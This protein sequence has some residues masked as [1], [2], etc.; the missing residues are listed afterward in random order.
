MT[1][2]RSAKLFQIERQLHWS[3]TRAMSTP[4]FPSK[5][6]VDGKWVSASSGKTFP[7]HNPANGQVLTNVPSMVNSDVEKAISA[8]SSAFKTW[9]TTPAKDRSILLRKWY[10]LINKKVDLFANIIHL[11]AGKSI[12]EAKTEVVYGN[13]FLEW[14]S[15][16]ARRAYG[17]VLC[18]PTNTKRLMHIR[19]P[20][21]V[22]AVITPWNFPLAMITRKAGAA[23]AAGCTCVVKPAEDTP[24]TALA[25]AECAAEAGI[26]RGVINVVTAERSNAGPVGQLLC[27]SPLV[28]VVTFT[29]STNVGKILYRHCAEGIKKISLELGGNA[30]FIVFNSADIGAATRGAI[31]SKFRNC[32]QT[33]VSANRFLLQDS[34]HDEFVEK[35]NEAM[36]ACLHLGPQPKSSSTMMQELG[37]LI[38]E[39]QLK[40]VDHMV[41]DAIEKGAKVVRGAKRATHLGDLYYEPTVLADVTPDMLC[42][43]EE[44]F[45]PV[46]SCIRFKTE[47]EVLRIANSSE[48]GLAGYFFSQDLS[49][50]FRV[51]EAL[52]VGMV[53]INEGAISTPEAAFGGVKQSGLGREGSYHG[54]E[55]FME[56][57]YMCF[58]NL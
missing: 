51:A 7:V 55:E 18:S 42:Y 36:D 24:I 25:L 5:C 49:Q 34:I 28:S 4:T 27:Q 22:A 57:K 38:N 13:S 40:K 11:E 58:G 45:G 12:A 1:L 46:V 56:W 35:L 21:G 19:Q 41:Q 39:A 2:V 8:A 43:N 54:L 37:P 32:G 50:I 3:Y 6:F 23:L 26:P 52:E 20:A 53:G 31:A 10:D 14:F 17:D 15:E 29:G 44:I 47:E 33:C 30:P 9:K 16:E 48:S